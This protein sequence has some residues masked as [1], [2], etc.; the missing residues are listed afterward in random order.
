MYL[1]WGRHS[2]LSTWEKLLYHWESPRGKQP[3]K[4]WQIWMS[5]SDD[6]HNCFIFFSM[7]ATH[8][9]Y[10]TTQSLEKINT[11]RAD[12][13]F[14]VSYMSAFT[15]FFYKTLPV[16][17]SL[18]H[19]FHNDKLCI[20][21]FVNALITAHDKSYVFPLVS[22]ATANVDFCIQITQLSPLLRKSWCLEGNNRVVTRYYQFFEKGW[23]FLITW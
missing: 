14:H 19:L 16:W 17:Q 11:S 6:C 15:I 12:N 3:V 2:S 22:P 21:C 10:E 7:L 5:N 8:I 18:P 13:S 9:L 4:G 1:I 23:F 20:K